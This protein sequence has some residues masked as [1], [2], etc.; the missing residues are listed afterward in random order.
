MGQSPQ[1]FLIRYR[2]AKAAELLKLTDLPIGKISA[3]VW[4]SLISFIFSGHSKYIFCLSKSVQT[5]IIK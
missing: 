4:I 3:Q 5:K 2:M 1:E